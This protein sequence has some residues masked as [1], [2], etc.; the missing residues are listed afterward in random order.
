MIFFYLLST[1]ILVFFSKQKNQFL[2]AFFPR[3]LIRGY[4]LTQL[5]LFV[6]HQF[7]LDFLLKLILVYGLCRLQILWACLIPSVFE[8]FW[9]IFRSC[10]LRYVVVDIILHMKC[11]I[12]VGAPRW[13]WSP[14]NALWC[15]HSEKAK[16]SLNFSCTNQV[17]EA[18][19]E[20]I[21]LEKKKYDFCL[22]G[23]NLSVGIH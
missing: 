4:V 2:Y 6:E 8:L 18:F 1:K 9:T 7:R 21:L 10:S 3:F 14:M 13:L 12:L 15:L 16:V 5:N 23:P 22:V 20:H 17:D 11:C 19:S